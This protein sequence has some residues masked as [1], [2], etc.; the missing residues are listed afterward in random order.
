[1]V[2]SGF[3]VAVAAF[4]Q[5]V[6]VNAACPYMDD[7][8]ELPASH[9][10]VRRDGSPSSPSVPTDEFMAA[11]EVNDT[12]VFLTGNAG[13][14]IGDQ[15]SLSAGERGPTLLEDFIFREK[16]MHFGMYSVSRIQLLIG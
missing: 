5:L 3:L 13:G 15:D 14:P 10:P 7:A 12:S 1:M 16:I 9:P 2:R 11:F 8:Q 4:V 6:D